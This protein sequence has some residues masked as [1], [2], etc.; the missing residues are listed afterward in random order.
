MIRRFHRQ[1]NWKRAF[2]MSSISRLDPVEIDTLTTAM[3]PTGPNSVLVAKEGIVFTVQRMDP[4]Q[5]ES[6]RG[7]YV[8]I[9]ADATKYYAD[10]LKGVREWVRLCCVAA[11]ETLPGHLACN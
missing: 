11:S 8:V 5:R 6:W 3:I 10:D 2:P 4:K 7:P 1:R 9:E